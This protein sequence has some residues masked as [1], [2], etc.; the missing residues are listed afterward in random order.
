M[1]NGQDNKYDSKSE[2]TQKNQYRHKYQPTLF[3]KNATPTK[4]R[5]A[6]LAHCIEFATRGF[7][8]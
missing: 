3:D 7:Q 5:N 8:L 6:T 4:F 2:I 1:G